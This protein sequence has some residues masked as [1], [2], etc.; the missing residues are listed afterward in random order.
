MRKTAADRK[1]E[2]INGLVEARRRLIQAVEEAP[3]DRR[4]DIF[5]GEWCVKDL[6]AH[7]VG[8]DHTNQRAVQEILSGQAPSLFLSYD[9][10]WQSYNARLVQD[11]RIEPFED[12]LASAAD[13]HAQLILYLQSLSAD[14][15]VNGKGHSP[16]GRTIT[17]RN[18]LAAEAEDEGKHFEQVRTF[19]QTVNVVRVNDSAV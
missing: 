14:D 11:Y 8:W 7:L 1:A 2:L 12:L 18:L 6:L 3:A 4:D 16:K 5:L 10:D 17:I 9:K 19:L 15:V 13:S